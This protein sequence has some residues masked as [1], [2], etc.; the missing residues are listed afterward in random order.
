MSFPAESIG[1]LLK[2]TA[3]QYHAAARAGCRP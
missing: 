1:D 3:K 2:V